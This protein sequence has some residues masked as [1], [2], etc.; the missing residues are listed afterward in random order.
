MEAESMYKILSF[1]VSPFSRLFFVYDYSLSKE[2]G[3]NLLIA[4]S[5]SN[6]SIEFSFMSDKDELRSGEELS[7]SYWE[8]R[9]HWGG[10]CT[11]PCWEGGGCWKT[12][13]VSE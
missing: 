5:S 13:A 8:G 4:S 11:W 9:I 12:L 3:G 6:S 1:S 2:C 10:T 7:D